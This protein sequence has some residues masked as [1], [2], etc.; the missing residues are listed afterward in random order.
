MNRKLYI[1]FFIMAIPFILQAA[2]SASNRKDQTL[3][4][5]SKSGV[6]FFYATASPIVLEIPG[7]NWTFGLANGSGVYSYTTSSSGTSKTLSV[8]TFNR[9]Y[10]KILHWKFI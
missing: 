4:L 2:D 9:N 3:R 1:S 7:E 10:W 8:N 5:G 6:H